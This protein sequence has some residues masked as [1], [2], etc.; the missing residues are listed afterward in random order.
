MDRIY[1]RWGVVMDIIRLI[2]EAHENAIDKGFYDCPECDGDG[3][4]HCDE[5][6]T[7]EDGPC[8]CNMPAGSKCIECNGSKKDP[9]KNIGELLMLIVSELGE[10]L[11]AHRKGRFANPSSL[12][13]VSDYPDKKQEAIYLFESGIKDTFEDEIADVFIRLFDLCGYLEVKNIEINQNY[14]ELSLSE[15]I[16]EHLLIITT[17]ICYAKDDIISVTV[18]SLGIAIN[19]LMDLCDRFNIPIEKHIEAKMAYNRTREHKH[20][21]A[22]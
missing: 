18:Q 10:A 7:L 12:V 19:C 17:F 2:K 6:G 21:K 5:G 3:R 14:S 22:Y 15:N 11:E 1:F 8:T 16:G 20:G 13:N 4:F 9:N